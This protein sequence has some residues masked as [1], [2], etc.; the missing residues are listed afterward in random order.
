MWGGGPENMEM[1]ENEGR[2]KLWKTYK[3]VGKHMAY[4]CAGGE[5]NPYMYNSTEGEIDRRTRYGA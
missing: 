4:H 1:C 3:D 2:C 5:E